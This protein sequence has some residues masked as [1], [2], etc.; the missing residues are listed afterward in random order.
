MSDLSAFFVK[1]NQAR[2]DLAGRTP[3]LLA[4]LWRGG[5]VVAEVPA[6]IVGVLSR[7][8]GAYFVEYLHEPGETYAAFGY[9]MRLV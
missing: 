6:R 9:R 3:I 2:D 1:A 7:D 4:P 5:T 8:Q